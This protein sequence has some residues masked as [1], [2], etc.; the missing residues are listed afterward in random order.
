M[1]WLPGIESVHCVQCL[2]AMSRLTTQSGFGCNCSSNSDTVNLNGG[3]A[4]A[5]SKWPLA[6]L[7]TSV[8]IMGLKLH[9]TRQQQPIASKSPT[10]STVSARGGRLG[11]SRAGSAGRG[12]MKLGAAKLAKPEPDFEF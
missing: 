9:S 12:G 6:M 3:P 5:G 11:A 4:T 7:A 1:Q 8:Q 10:H 2:L